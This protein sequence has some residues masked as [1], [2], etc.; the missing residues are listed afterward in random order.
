MVHRVSP[1]DASPTVCQN[2]IEDDLPLVVQ[3]G[4][5]GVGNKVRDNRAGQ[6]ISFT[7]APVADRVS[8]GENTRAS[9][10]ERSQKGD[11]HR[12]R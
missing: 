5:D 7:D 10:L 4:T 11:L 1:V 6:C 8:T 12:R 9:A 3:A 2:H